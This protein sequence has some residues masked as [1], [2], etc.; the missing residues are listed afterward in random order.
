MLCALT[1]HDA[2]AQIREGRISSRQ[3]V[4]ACLTRIDETD[5]QLKAWAHIDRDHAMAQADAMDAL[6]R[7]G[8]PLGPLH[9]VPVG[10]KDII[11]TADLP[12]ERGSPIHAGRRPDTDSAIV[13]KLREA[14]A[15]ILGKTVTTE[16]AFM[17]PAAT[18]NPHDASRGPGGSSAGSAAAVA[19]GQVPIAVGTQTNGSTIRPASFCGVYGLKPTHGMISRRGVLE[20]SASLDQVG[21]F[22]RC[23]EDA[24]LLTDSLKGFDVADAA[25]YA[26]PKP[27]V[28]GTVALDP[29]VEPIFAWLDLPYFDR[30][31]EAARVGLEELAESLGDRL[32]RI[33]APTGLGELVEDHQAVQS[34]EIARNLAPQADAHWDRISA[35]VQGL[36]ESGRAVTD[37]RYEAAKTAIVQ[38]GEFFDAF[39]IDYDAILTPSAAGEAPAYGDGTGDPIFCTIWTACGLPSL[40]LPVLQGENGLPIGAQLVGSLESDG[41]LLRTGRWLERHLAAHGENVLENA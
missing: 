11:D 39:F 8:K 3:L 12:T 19:A 1:A 37:A 18:A 13:E 30:L 32:E 14:G 35:P 17:T 26:R 22:A 27:D 10:L 7:S 36:I 9:G 21:I 29:P 28:T 20:T 23:L 25:C 16:F 4:E 33:P 2:T 6:R 40:T 24:A 31:S 15:V 5:G 34:Y 41:A 38:A